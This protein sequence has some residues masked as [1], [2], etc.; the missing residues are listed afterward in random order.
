MSIAQAEA[1]ILADDKAGHTAQSVGLAE[2][3][4]LRYELKDLRF[5]PLQLLSNRLLGASLVSLDR[6]RSAPLVPP[7]PKLIICA[8]RRSVPTAR[9]IASRRAGMRIVHLGRKGGER[10]DGF[11]ALVSCAH[12]GLASHPRRVET[13]TALHAMSPA[14]LA[15]A[16]EHW[17]GLFGDA[18]R[19]H[20]VLVVGGNT[21]QHVLD[22][23][24]AERMGAEVAA[25]AKAA[26]GS[27]FA[28]TSPRTGAAATE[29]LSK[30][31]GE[32]G[33]VHRWKPGQTDNPYTGHLA[34]ADVLVVTGESE[35]MLSEAAATGAPLF[36]Y[37]VPERPVG[38]RARIRSWTARM[39]GAAQ[40]R[41]QHASGLCSLVGGAS[42]WL[43]ASDLVRPNRDLV[44]MHEGLIRA[45]VAHRFG[46]PIVLDRREPVYE[47]PVVAR[48]LQVLL[49][50]PE[51]RVSAADS[52]P[53][54]MAA[55]RK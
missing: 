36:I 27:L 1:W 39:A 26:G 52:A 10:P 54:T 2:A 14:R 30:G 31:I 53:Q 25:F 23:A 42:R 47:I 40:G 16:A 44:A 13:L 5:N 45:G 12:F 7:W 43:L 28:I 15:E 33:R 41:E 35:S 24:S 4:G 32:A 37:P 18:P 17:R 46:E 48:R 21:A 29:G 34:L 55:A 50:L 9:W 20:V 3:L 19:P 6:K 38:L 11:S 51:S 22:A 49:N 8:G